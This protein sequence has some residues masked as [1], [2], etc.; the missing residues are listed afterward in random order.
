MSG[1]DF[2]YGASSNVT[3]YNFTIPTGLGVNT[4]SYDYNSLNSYGLGGTTGTMGANTSSIAGLGGAGSTDLSGLGLNIP[5]LQLGLSGISSLAGLYTG[6]KSLGLAQDQFDLTKQ[7]YQTNLANQTKSYNTA[8]S[9]KAT[10]RGVMEG[11]NSDQV[12]AYIKAN[13]L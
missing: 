13:S 7:A 3:P 11:Q 5:T 2:N 1:L 4:N 9:D 10:A 12:A 6:L 8:L